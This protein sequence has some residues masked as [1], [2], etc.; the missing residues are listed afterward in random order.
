[1]EGDADDA[2][3]PCSSA[4][5]AKDFLTCHSKHSPKKQMIEASFMRG[6]LNK[7]PAIG[8]Q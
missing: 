8:F 4:I 5:F 1:M 7:Q 6:I 2:K 3:G